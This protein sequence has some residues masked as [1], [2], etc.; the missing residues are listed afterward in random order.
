MRAENPIRL[1]RELKGAPLSIYLV[2][3]FVHQ[4]VTQEYLE[5]ATG[6]TDKPVSQGL[7]YLAEIGMVEHNRSGWALCNGVRQLQ[8]PLGERPPRGAPLEQMEPQINNLPRVL[9]VADEHGSDITADP[10]TALPNASAGESEN[11]TETVPLSRKNSDSLISLITTTNINP[12]INLDISSS[13]NLSAEGRKNSDSAPDFGE[14]LDDYQEPLAAFGCN[15]DREGYNPKAI[16]EALRMC[17]VAEPKLSALALLKDICAVKVWALYNE[18]NRI[19][20]ERYGP[21]LLIY[22]LEHD[23]RVTESAWDDARQEWWE[24]CRD[25]ENEPECGD[26]GYVC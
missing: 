2:L 13:S 23:Q 18:L 6:Y 10:S 22:A 19:K 9:A 20:G 8:L 25:V 15:L 17:Q 1:V 7:A 3:G 5:R 12:L 24:H 4:R 21:G 14:D 11:E 26:G 16:R